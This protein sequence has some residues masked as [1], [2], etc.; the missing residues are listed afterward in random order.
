MFQRQGEAA[1]R[2]AEER[3][4]LELLD[5]DDVAVLALGGGAVG[6]GAVRRALADHRVVWLDIDP[7]TAWARVSGGGRPLARERPAFERLH[8]ER[9]TLYA[10]LADVVVPAVRSREVGPVLD[11]VADA[12]SRYF[13]EIRE[14][15]STSLRTLMTGVLN[16]RSA[17]SATALSGSGQ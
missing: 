3:L 11:A 9:E 1:F 13:F 6:S 4:T 10:E 2:A 14:Q 8:S 7:G 15:N 16:C 17:F 5:A 12:P